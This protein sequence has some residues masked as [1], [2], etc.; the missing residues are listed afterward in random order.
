MDPSKRWPQQLVDSLATAGIKVNDPTYIAKT[1]WR[2]DD[3][4]KA[5][6]KKIGKAQFDMVSL[7]IG[8]NNEY[9]QKSAES[10]EPEFKKCLKYAIKHCKSGKEGVFVVSIPDYGYTPFGSENQ[11]IIS[12]RLD[13]YNEICQRISEEMDV[14]Y[15]NITPISRQDKNNKTLVAKD[16]LHPSARQ[17]ALWVASFKSEVAKMFST[18]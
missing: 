8:V 4:L 11:A 2:T 12:E 10:F 15:F 17:Y 5:A 16:G 3:M 9:Q 7:L 1:G 13:A 14:A 6:K 18:H